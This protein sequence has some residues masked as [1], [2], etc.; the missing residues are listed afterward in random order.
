MIFVTSLSLALDCPFTFVFFC[1]MAEF[2]LFFFLLILTNLLLH[3]SILLISHI[4]IRGIQDSPVF[5]YLHLLDSCIHFSYDHTTLPNWLTLSLFLF[6]SSL[7]FTCHFCKLLTG[8]VI[9]YW[10]LQV[11]SLLS[12]LYLPIKLHF[13]IYSFLCSFLI[14]EFVGFVLHT[15]KP[16]LTFIFWL[17]QAN[18]DIVINFD[19][20]LPLTIF[21]LLYASLL[22]IRFLIKLTF[23]TFIYPSL[24]C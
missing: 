13:H 7:K 18:F 22:F 15:F 11:I 10:H 23:F 8:F 20:S 17:H 9:Q 1:F 4:F 5:S 14:F 24:L 3:Y 12:S 19:A 6:Q 2:L 21:S 16:I